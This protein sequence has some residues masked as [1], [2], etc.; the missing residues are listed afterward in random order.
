MM[1]F[2]PWLDLDDFGC[3]MVSLALA[4]DH[5]G[6]PPPHL[7]WGTPLE[8]IIGTFSFFPAGKLSKAPPSAPIGTPYRAQGDSFLT[9][10]RKG[11]LLRADW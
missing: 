3:L 9:I 1:G 2:Y 7:P 6:T 11:C 10:K 4:D 8:V 5:A